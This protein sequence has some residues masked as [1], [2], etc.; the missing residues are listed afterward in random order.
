MPQITRK[1]RN[2]IDKV[3][4][5][6]PCFAW[7]PSPFDPHAAEDAA[8]SVVYGPD[9]RVTLHRGPD[10]LYGVIEPPEPKP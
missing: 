8:G 6:G 10:G 5:D 4:D 3:D 1:P 9:G 7:G 2:P